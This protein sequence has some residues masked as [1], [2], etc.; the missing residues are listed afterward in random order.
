GAMFDYTPN[1]YYAYQIDL[2][3]KL[4]PSGNSVEQYTIDQERK[5]IMLSDY[6]AIIRNTAGYL[7]YDFEPIE[8]LRIS[9]GL[10]YDVMSFTYE[11]YLDQSSG[12]KAYSR[13][14]PKLGLTYDLGR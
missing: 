5:D 6:D 10:R 2:H 9:G 14:T 8:R 7:Q 12:N 1:T 3:A 4:R 11:N 13:L